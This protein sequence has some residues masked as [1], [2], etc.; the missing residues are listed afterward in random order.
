MANLYRPIHPSEI[1][2]SQDEFAA[3][4]EK[5]RPNLYREDARW[6]T[7]WEYYD[8]THPMDDSQRKEARRKSYKDWYQKLTDSMVAKR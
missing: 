6:L 7:E 5:I 8:H 1:L 4:I 2:L 3:L